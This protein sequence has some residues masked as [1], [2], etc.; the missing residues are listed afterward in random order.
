MPPL[1][2]IDGDILMHLACRYDRWQQKC[3]REGDVLLVEINENGYVLEE[4]TKEEDRKYMEESWKN[5]KK[6]LNKIQDDCWS[7]DFKMAVRG[8]NNFRDEIWPEYKANR[9]RQAVKNPSRRIEFVKAITELAVFEGYAVPAHGREADDL[10]RIWAEECIKENREHIVVTND[11]DL[12]CIPGKFYDPKENVLFEVDAETAMANYYTQLLCGDSTDNIPGVPG[13]GV[14]GATN[15]ISTLSTEEEY[16]EAVIANYISAYQDEWHDML[17]LN[18][19]LI[20]I[21]RTMDDVFSVDNWPLA[22]ELRGLM[23]DQ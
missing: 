20:H 7:S 6:L 9:R 17:I 22:I 18:G 1:L 13:L 10:V 21:Q 3:K 19:K 16:Q 5:F 11:K 15:L 23:N 4:F 14:K 2:C 12:R 8:D